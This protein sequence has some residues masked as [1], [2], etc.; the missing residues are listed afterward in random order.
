MVIRKATSQETNEIIEYAPLVMKEAT[1]GHTQNGK[2]K[3]LQ[4]ISEFL[5]NGGYYLVYTEDDVIQGWIGVV[6]SYNVYS[7]EVDPIIV[8]LYV[9]PGYRKKG[10][11]QRLL[12]NTC[13]RLKKEGY[14]R[15]QLNVFAGNPVKRLY[16]KLGFYDIS[17]IMKKDL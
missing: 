2:D 8:E 1:M 11:A 5:S 7:G 13:K 3:A 12:E 4:Q 15:V 10:I 14:R 6:I 9:L 16:K 17:T